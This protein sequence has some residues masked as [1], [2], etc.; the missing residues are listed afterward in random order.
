M[1]SATVVLRPTRAPAPARAARAASAAGSPSASVS[2]SHCIEP[3]QQRVDRRRLAACAA[4]GLAI[5]RA[6]QTA[7]SSRITSPFSRSVVPVA[8]RS[9]IASASPV[10]GASSTDPLTSTISAWRPVSRK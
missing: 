4:T 10:S 6:V 8:V 1:I 5:S 7:I 9:T 2:R 3:L